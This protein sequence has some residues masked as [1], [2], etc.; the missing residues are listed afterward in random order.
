[1]YSGL[2]RLIQKIRSVARVTAS[3]TRDEGGEARVLDRFWMSR[4]VYETA[5]RAQLSSLVLENNPSAS[6]QVQSFAPVPGFD[7]KVA[8]PLQQRILGLY[9]L[10]GERDDIDVVWMISKEPELL[11]VGFDHITNRLIELRTSPSA[12]GLDVV[13]LVER[14]P[15]LL[16]AEGNIA[17]SAGDEDMDQTR[18]AW[19]SGLLGDGDAEWNSRLEQLEEY[20][21]T[22]G[23]VHVGFRESDDGELVMWATKQRRERKYAKRGELSAQNESSSLVAESRSQRWQKLEVSFLCLSCHV[24]D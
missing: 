1:M 21:K 7:V 4:G 10:L 24:D 14:Q 18:L 19:E 13:K 9:R 17:T 8:I 15:R 16:V 3:S 22:W 2:T 20:R 12:Q 5:H 23:D 11:S 6:A